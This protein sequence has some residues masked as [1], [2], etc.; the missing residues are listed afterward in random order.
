MFVNYLLRHLLFKNEGVTKKKNKLNKQE[1][2]S[3]FRADIDNSFYLKKVN[4]IE[5]GKKINVIN[6]LLASGYRVLALR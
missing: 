3:R 2:S 5:K 1:D 6:W 4:T